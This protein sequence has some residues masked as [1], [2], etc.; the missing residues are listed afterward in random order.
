VSSIAEPRSL[1]GVL[2]EPRCAVANASASGKQQ[3]SQPK[4][5]VDLRAHEQVGTNH[6]DR[7]ASGKQFKPTVSFTHVTRRSKRDD[8]HC[9]QQDDKLDQEGYAQ[10]TPAPPERKTVS[11]NRVTK[12]QKLPVRPALLQRSNQTVKSSDK[13]RDAL[14]SALRNSPEHNLKFLPNNE[15]AQL[16]T[17]ESVTQ[18]LARHER[19]LRLKKR[20]APKGSRQ[21]RNPVL[22]LPGQ[23]I[24][25]S[26]SIGTGIMDRVFSF[27]EKKDKIETLARKICGM[28]RSPGGE[29]LEYRRIFAILVL[30]RMSHKISRFVKVNISDTWL[31]LEAHMVSNQ[32]KFFRRVPGMSNTGKAA[33]SR[34]DRSEKNFYSRKA[35]S[36]EGKPVLKPLKCFRGWNG[37]QRGLFENKQWVVL[38]PTFDRG[39]FE[40]SEP[41]RHQSFRPENILPF[42]S[43][44][45]LRSENG[46]FGQVYQVEI[47]SEHHRFGT[48]EVWLC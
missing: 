7:D 6:H 3:G 23:A 4:T 8:L 14:H 20:L 15:L 19:S 37:E 38:A 33:P 26:K 40:D 43:R 36:G 39:G 31:P 27:D 9:Q 17:L 34:H 12:D 46:A 24:Q 5:S 41:V 45:A 11:S 28:D 48:P 18:E 10:P 44:V 30:I 47:H 35:N 13:L 2:R 16:I 32:I 29:R 1:G 25:V 21:K 42:T 22:A